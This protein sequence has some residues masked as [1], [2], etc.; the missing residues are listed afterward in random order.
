MI[1]L[2][3]KIKF[4]GRKARPWNAKDNFIGRS[5]KLPC[6][7]EGAVVYSLQSSV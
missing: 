1:S 5:G 4:V 3:K 2:K 7:K 6:V